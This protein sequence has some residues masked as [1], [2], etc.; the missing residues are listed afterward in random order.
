MLQKLQKGIQLFNRLYLLE[1]TLPLYHGHLAVIILKTSF[2]SVAIRSWKHT[3]LFAKH[4][5]QL[6]GKPLGLEIS[7]GGFQLVALHHCRLV[8]MD[9]KSCPWQQLQ[10]VI[11]RN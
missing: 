10:T 5:T 11:D 1:K 9:R 7:V 8:D 4:F 3:G 2:N 6:P